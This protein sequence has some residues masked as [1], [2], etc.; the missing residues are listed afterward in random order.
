VVACCRWGPSCCGQGS[1]Q[2][3]AL[4]GLL[5][6]CGAWRLMCSSTRSLQASHTGYNEQLSGVHKEGSEFPPRAHRQQH[7]FPERPSCS[8]RAIYWF[9]ISSMKLLTFAQDAPST[10]HAW[11]ILVADADL[12]M[13]ERTISSRPHPQVVLTWG[14]R[15]F[16]A[17]SWLSC[18]AHMLGFGGRCYSQVLDLH[19]NP[20]CQR[21]VGHKLQK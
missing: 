5:Q 2:G 18:T 1:C 9:A 10:E 4:G 8:N 13:I 11:P 20:H 3:R 19:I 7:A 12:C 14:M 17:R 6:L 15:S 21:V 16:T